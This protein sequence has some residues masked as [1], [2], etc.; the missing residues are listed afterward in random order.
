MEELIRAVIV[1][2]FFLTCPFSGNNIARSSSLEVLHAK[3]DLWAGVVKRWLGLRLA[4]F[5]ALL[6]AALAAAD[7]VRWSVELCGSGCVPSAG[8]L[9][10]AGLA[11]V[12]G[13]GHVTFLAAPACGVLGASG[14][15]PCSRPCLLPSLL[16]VPSFPW[17]GG[18]MPADLAV[19]SFMLPALALL[20]SA[21]D[22]AHLAPFSVGCCWLRPLQLAPLLVWSTSAAARLLN[23]FFAQTPFDVVGLEVITCRLL[24]CQCCVTARALGMGWAWICLPHVVFIVS[25]FMLPALVLSA[26]VLDS[27]H[28][29]PF[30]TASCWLCPLQLVPLLVW[31]TPAAPRLS[32]LFFAQAPFDVVGSGV[33]SG[34]LLCCRVGRSIQGLLGMGR[35]GGGAVVCVGV[36][37][38]S[39]LRRMGMGRG[40]GERGRARV[41]CV[42]G[43][44]GVS[45]VRAVGMCAPCLFLSFAWLMLSVVRA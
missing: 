40:M 23:L 19:S 29:A 1:R 31:S 30:S 22:S 10:L 21:L 12:T 28:L 41:D 6:V 18:S 4:V 37:V 42:L 26:T 11:M 27:A 20:A 38:G 44:S 35:V 7:G 17:M 5:G 24:G 25:S 43:L 33:A 14:S 39:G 13:A 3:P 9:V 8:V 16:L 34:T 2:N 32:N 15:A 36:G 45:I